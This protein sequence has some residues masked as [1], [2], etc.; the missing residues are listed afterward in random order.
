MDLVPI[1]TSLLSGGLAG[2][3]VSTI[4]N[5]IFHWRDLR[6]RFYPK[7]NDMY[8]NYV[9]RMDRP[10]GRYWDTIVGNNPSPQDEEFVD[11]RSTFVSDLVQFNELK[12]ARI[13]RKTMVE[14]LASGH[15]TQG[16]PTRIDLMPELR[17][18]DACL[19]LLHRKLKI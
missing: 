16:Q 7:I 15:H 2:G 18:L 12:E 9:I 11:H 5:R 14:N 4:L 10:S 8:A 6:T 17:A 3:C 19:K 1:I 13:L